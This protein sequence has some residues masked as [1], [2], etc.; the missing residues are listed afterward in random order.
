MAPVPAGASVPVPSTVAPS[1]NVTVPVG[2]TPSPLT[3]SALTVTSWV[4]T[5]GLTEP[6]TVT[7]VEFTYSTAPASHT[8]P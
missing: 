8:P 6:A 5:D 4:R 1:L 7:L 3:T 2:T